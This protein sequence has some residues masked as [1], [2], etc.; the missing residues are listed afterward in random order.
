MLVAVA[1]VCTRQL[2]AAMDSLVA[3]YP[4]LES[5]EATQLLTSMIESGGTAVQQT[6]LQAL[7]SASAAS[8][9]PF[10]LVLLAPTAARLAAE[11]CCAVQPLGAAPA[12]IPEQLQQPAGRLMI[13]PDQFVANPAGAF[14]IF[15]WVAGRS[16]LQ[17]RGCPHRIVTPP[18][19]PLLQAQWQRQRRRTRR[20]RHWPTCWLCW[21]YKKAR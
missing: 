7:T 16:A 21:A 9:S 12:P 1:R 4:H 8:A 3:R 18:L 5:R 10:S 11:A 14:A 17:H 13:H 2:K 19:T 6:L 15:C 20:C